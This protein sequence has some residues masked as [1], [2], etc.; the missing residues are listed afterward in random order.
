MR[1]TQEDLIA[2]VRNHFEK[3]LMVAEDDIYLSYHDL[4]DRVENEFDYDR[5]A[6]LLQRKHDELLRIS[7][8]LQFSED[9]EREADDLLELKNFKLE[10]FTHIYRRFVE[11]LVEAKVEAARLTLAKFTKDAEAL[12]IRV[13]HLK[14]CRNYLT[15]PDPN[16]L[17]YSSFL[18][19]FHQS[20]SRSSN[21]NSTLSEA[22]NTYL[23][24]RN[25]P[26]TWKERHR[27]FL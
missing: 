18:T 17:S 27:A 10:R 19:P 26:Q 5:K 12:T 25:E 16:A 9:I 20:D 11:D 13:E 2:L 6:N 8:T 1:P 24:Y 21:N 7:Q 23:E 4:R 15:N 3:S 22:I 14:A